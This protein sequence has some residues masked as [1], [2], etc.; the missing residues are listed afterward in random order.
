MFG[1]LCTRLGKWGKTQSS[2]FQICFCF[3][4]TLFLLCDGTM[5]GKLGSQHHLIGII[6]SIIF[7]FKWV[8]T[9]VRNEHL[10]VL[11]KWAF[12]SIHLFWLYV[13]VHVIAQNV[14]FF[15]VI[16]WPHSTLCVHLGLGTASKRR[17][18]CF[19][20]GRREGRPKLFLALREKNTLNHI[21]FPL[22][23]KNLAYI[24]K[25]E[26]FFLFQPSFKV[27]SSGLSPVC[28]A[29]LGMF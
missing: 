5:S 22:L 15:R 9:V 16:T 17:C 26:V 24:F 19:K 23:L 11:I 8:E 27:C 28:G 13:L 29:S 14:H 6:V 20:W 4:L 3:Y 12:H 10:F 18:F 1:S 21:L 25:R 2:Q 7:S